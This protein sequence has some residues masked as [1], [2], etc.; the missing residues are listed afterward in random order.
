[1]LIE[2]QE[3]SGRVGRDDSPLRVLGTLGRLIPGESS[4]QFGE[5]FH[6]MQHGTPCRT[7]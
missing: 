4:Q 6:G 1:M 2:T 5:K 3:E 7:F